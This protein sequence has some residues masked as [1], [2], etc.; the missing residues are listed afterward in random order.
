MSLT[1]N[2]QP[3]ERRAHARHLADLHVQLIRSDTLPMR[4]HTVELSMGGMRVECDQAKAQL[5]AP[6]DIGEG[7][8]FTARLVLSTPK[9]EHRT[10]TL[11]ATV[12]SVQEVAHDH[13][14][15]GMRFLKFFGKS[16]ALLDEFIAALKT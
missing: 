10:L 8:R 6:P 5:L 11:S 9:L 12:K 13:Y 4:L 7:R 16:H 14:R 1:D 3:G 15:I 2:L